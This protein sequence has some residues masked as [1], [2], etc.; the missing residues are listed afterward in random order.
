MKVC[1]RKRM[2]LYRK[3]EKGQ[4][5]VARGR[6][7]SRTTGYDTCG[8]G[9]WN[10]LRKASIRRGHPFPLTTKELKGW[11]ESNEDRCHYCRISLKL[12]L[13]I[14]DFVVEYKGD[15]LQITKFQRCL[16]NSKHQK[17]EKMTI[18]RLDNDVGYEYHNMVKAC[19]FCN[20]LKGDFFTSKQWKMIAPSMVSDLCEEI[21]KV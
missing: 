21:D 16:K 7:K 13:I 17:I 19:W 4:E 18:D 8:K 10:R 14:R 11:W 12:Y 3:T 20:Y 15:N 5:A 2:A 9:A 1:H 6:K